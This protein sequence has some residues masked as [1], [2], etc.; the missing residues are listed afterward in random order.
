M[1]Q[2]TATKGVAVVG[3]G[4]AGCAA[5]VTLAARGVPVTLLESG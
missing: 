5:A 2:G 3:A 1:D 4:Y